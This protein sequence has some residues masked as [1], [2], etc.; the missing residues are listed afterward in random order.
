MQLCKSPRRRLILV[1]IR[2]PRPQRRL[3]R[4]Y[5][6]GKVLMWTVKRFFTA[7]VI[8]VTLLLTTQSAFA[9]N[10]YV[11]GDLRVDLPQVR[12]AGAYDLLLYTPLDTRPSGS[13]DFTTAW[14][15]LY[16][17]NGPNPGGK[18]FSQVGLIVRPDGLRWFVFAEPGVT[19]HRGTA[20]YGTLGCQGSVG[21]IVA[22]GNYYRVELR[23]VSSGWHAMIYDTYSNPYVLA[24]INSTSGEIFRAQATTEQGYSSS[25]NPYTPAY[26]YHYHPR[27]YVSAPYNYAQWPQ[28]ETGITGVAPKRYSEI[29]TWASSQVNICPTHYGANPNVAGDERFWFAGTGGIVC[30]HLLFPPKVFLPLIQR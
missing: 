16:L 10:D 5:R 4:A 11:I 23:R 2:K 19:C 27:Y 18:Q 13:G 14:L 29:W 22:T 9:N 24:T 7:I 1:N 30:N 26:Y 17:A 6:K 8:T 21:D 15:G 12:N 25:P 20:N 3:A 28:S